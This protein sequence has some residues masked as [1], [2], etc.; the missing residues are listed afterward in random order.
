MR[1]GRYCHA[2]ESQWSGLSSEQQQRLATGAQRWA[3]MDSQQR[4]TIQ[5][6]FSR[7]QTLSPERRADLTKRFERFKSL[8]PEQQQQ[9]R[10]RMQNFPQ[11]TP[12]ATAAPA[13]PVSCDV[14]AAARTGAQSDGRQQCRATSTRAAAEAMTNATK[15]PRRSVLYMPGANARAMEKARELACDTIIFDL[16]DAVAPDAKDAARVQVA[17]R[18][19][20]A[21]T[22]IANSYC[23]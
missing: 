1:N 16:E 7:W 9:L 11:L 13:R 22:D 5:K 19:A 20:A 21:A 17:A 3:T 8:S 10:M 23:A 2:I 6:R 15:P 14:A 4:A 18:F 12:G